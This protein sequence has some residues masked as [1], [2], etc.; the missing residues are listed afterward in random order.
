MCPLISALAPIPPPTRSIVGTSQDVNELSEVADN[1]HPQPRNG[2]NLPS[3][4]GGDEYR[5]NPV[6]VRRDRG[7][8]GAIDPA[9]RTVQSEFAD[10]CRISQGRAGNL[11]RRREH[12]DGYRQV[13][14]GA[15]LRKVSRR[16]P[17]GDAGGWP[18]GTDIADG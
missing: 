9:H 5:T 12:S 14:A 11:R 8:E 1:P 10:E 4:C 15:A 7:G 6:S 3:I 16:K 18:G 2:L 17:D 13:K